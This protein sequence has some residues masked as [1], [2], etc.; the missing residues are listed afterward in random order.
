MAKNGNDYT[1]STDAD[2][3]ALGE[4]ESL[5]EE[6]HDEGL[7][8]LAA[9]EESDPYGEPEIDDHQGAGDATEVTV[10]DGVDNDTSGV[11][12]QVNQN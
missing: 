6:V 7:V 9:Q 8:E 12:D 11:E 10:P 4:T 3:D 1:F 2:A 5:T